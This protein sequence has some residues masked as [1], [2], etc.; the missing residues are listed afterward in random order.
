M[1]PLPEDD[2]RKSDDQQAWTSVQR[3]ALTRPVD[4][5]VCNVIERQTTLS[6]DTCP[7]Q[8]ASALRGAEGGS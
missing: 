7:Q 3:H 8:E 1:A 6:E 2:S 4:E 5:L